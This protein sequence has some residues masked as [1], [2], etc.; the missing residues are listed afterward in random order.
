MSIAGAIHG[1]AQP[2]LEGHGLRLSAFN[3]AD[4]QAILEG[5]DARVQSQR[6][7]GETL[8]DPFRRR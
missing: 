4:L 6:P 5:A 8:R 3:L 2:Q 1:R 7:L